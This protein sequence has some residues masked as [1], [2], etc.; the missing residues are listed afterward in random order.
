MARELAKNNPKAV[1]NLIKDW[2]EGKE[3]KKG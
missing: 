3:E 1:A 2:L